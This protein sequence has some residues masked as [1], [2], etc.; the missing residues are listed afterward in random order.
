VT[1]ALHYVAMQFATGDSVSGAPATPQHRTAAIHV[2][3]TDK[4]L[5]CDEQVKLMAL[6]I[7][8]IAAVDSYLAFNNAELHTEFIRYQLTTLI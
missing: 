2:V 6:F 3:T 8:N 4:N 7:T 5:T 1:N